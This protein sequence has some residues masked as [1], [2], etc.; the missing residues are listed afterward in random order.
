MGSSIL[1]KLYLGS[2]LK[3]IRRHFVG[4]WTTSW[5]YW[6]QALEGTGLF[7]GMRLAKPLS[8]SFN[9]P[10]NNFL[11][12]GFN[13]SCLNCVLDFIKLALLQK[14]QGL[15]NEDRYLQLRARR[16]PTASPPKLVGQLEDVTGFRSAAVTVSR[17]L[18]NAV[19]VHEDHYDA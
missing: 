16:V 5:A 18:A 17:R 6:N 12:V 8:T 1:H 3:S 19:F 11:K 4:Q 15:I 9:I 14:C 13:L 2:S 10:W 7:A